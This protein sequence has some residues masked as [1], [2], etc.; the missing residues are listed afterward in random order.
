[1]G[2][3]Y[4]EGYGLSVQGAQ[5]FGTVP[6]GGAEALGAPDNVGAANLA[7]TSSTNLSIFLTSALLGTATAQPTKVTVGT[8]LQVSNA[9]QQMTMTMMGV[10]GLGVDGV[11]R[12]FAVTAANTWQD[13]EWEL[14]P[15][16]FNPGSQRNLYMRLAKVSTAGSYVIR[17]DAAWIKL[18]WMET[19]VASNFHWWDGTKWL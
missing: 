13:F 18:D 2:P 9:A 3:Q 16:K 7:T 17:I 12:T 1:V 5:N 14:D 10:G 6:P 15:A 4:Y 19:N 11:A 8:R